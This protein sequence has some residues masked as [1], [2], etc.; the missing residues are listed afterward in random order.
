MVNKTV[1]D[2]GCGHADISGALYRLGADV[3]ALDARPEHLKMA[4]KKFP[5]IKTIKA[6]LDQSWPFIGK[7]FD[8]ILDM[9]VLCHLRNYES[10][11]R[12]VCSSTSYLVLETAVCNS[13][14]P[15][16]CVAIS[17][18]KS[19]YDLAANGTGCRPTAAA[20]EKV[21][22]ECGMDFKRMD[23]SKLNSGDNVY[24]WNTTN[25]GN[26]S[27]HNRR[28]WFAVK[29]NSIHQ[30]AHIPMTP[31][32]LLQPA[33][34]PIVLTPNKPVI[35][36]PI[37]ISP[38][39]PQIPITPPIPTA[40]PPVHPHSVGYVGSMNNYLGGYTTNSDDV[41]VTSKQFAILKPELWA[42][43]IQFSDVNGIVACT[44]LKAG[45]WFSKI[46]PLFPNILPHKSSY[47]LLEFNRVDGTPDLIM[48][49]I[50][51][52]Q[53]G[54]RVFIDEWA[55]RSLTNI[56]IQN[57]QK[58]F[59]ILTP[60]LINA[61]EILK[62]LPDANVIRTCR[63]WPALNLSPHAGSYLMYFEKDNN[64][65][66]KLLEQWNGQWS[67]LVVVGSSG[68]LPNFAVYIS[69]G[70]TYDT[71]VSTM[72]GAR[73]ILSLHKNN[74]YLSGIQELSK[75][76]GIPLITNNTAQNENN[77]II[78]V[79]DIDTNN[80]SNAIS[81][82]DEKKNLTFDPDYN[83]NFVYKNVRNLLGK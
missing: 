75:S 40:H 14:D 76:M 59:V 36:R 73:G 26:T 39:L 22:S 55:D 1:L 50:T 7:H 42:P 8:I 11:L 19:I 17:E 61:Q 18:N 71:V 54:N 80:L 2:L 28:L 12:A 21:L 31:Q 29:N 3:T 34:A 47:S 66:K 24:D 51:N 65:T 16:K 15:N 52:I 60:S 37:P 9:G 13:I 41:R 64:V 82:V 23:A 5:G 69:D 77:L 56:D 58:S 83:T 4:S 72:R 67:P 32:Q 53:S 62:V 35:S 79:A 25:S 68:R 27:I 78:N 63:P 10:H 46:S 74:Y 43:P 70:E 48:C 30:P 44:T 6:D 20:I 38:I 45:L 81:Q 57:L 33:V 49:D